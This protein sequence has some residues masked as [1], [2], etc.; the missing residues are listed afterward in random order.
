M[1]AAVVRVTAGRSAVE[2]RHGTVDCASQS[3]VKNYLT[4]SFPINPSLY[5]LLVI[6]DRCG[7]R[8]LEMLCVGYTPEL[9]LRRGKASPSAAAGFC[10]PEPLGGIALARR[11]FAQKPRGSAP[12]RVHSL[13]VCRGTHTV[14]ARKGVQFERTL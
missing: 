6:I 1:L 14:S 10:A 7:A 5:Q 2:K 4:C 8:A 11:A 13:S 9:G 12:Q 3:M